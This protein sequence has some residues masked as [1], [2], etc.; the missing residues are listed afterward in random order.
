MHWY[1]TGLL[2]FVRATDRNYH[3]QWL[4]RSFVARTNALLATSRETSHWTKVPKSSPNVNEENR[5][6]HKRRLLR[7]V[8]KRVYVARYSRS[9]ADRYGLGRGSC[10][11]YAERK[12]LH[13]R[14]VCS[15]TKIIYE[16]GRRFHF[17]L[18]ES[19]SRLLCTTTKQY[20]SWKN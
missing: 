17:R 14:S 1:R 8:C 10:W 18:N 6:K 20:W 16:E 19:I 4:Q 15:S 3:Q 9:R 2:G 11:F 12:Q 13:N 7:R 5:Q